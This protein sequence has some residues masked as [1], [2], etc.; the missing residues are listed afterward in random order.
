MVDRVTQIDYNGGVYGRGFISGEKQITP[1]MWP[2]KAHF[3]NDPVFPAIIVS[4]AVT[5]LGMFLFT[6]AGLLNK[7]PN[8][9]FTNVMDN[10]IKSRFRGQTRHG[11]STLRYEVSIKDLVEYED[12]MDLFYDAKIFN[13]EVQ[14]MQIDSYALRIRNAD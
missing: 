7:F 4:D 2:F 5:Q 13:D 11:Y 9:Y 1:D 8:P 12:H 3:K 10:C 6:H 14:I